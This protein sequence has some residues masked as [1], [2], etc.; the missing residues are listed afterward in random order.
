MPP[1]WSVNPRPEIVLPPGFAL[2]IDYDPESSPASLLITAYR[3]D[4]P[5]GQAHVDPREVGQRLRLDVADETT[6]ASTARELRLRLTPQR[7]QRAIV[8][9]AVR[10]PAQAREGVE[11]VEKASPLPAQAATSELPVVQAQPAMSQ[12]LAIPTQSS[13]PALEALHQLARDGVPEDLRGYDGDGP[14]AHNALVWLNNGTAV[15]LPS[16]SRPRPLHA[17]ATRVGRQLREEVAGEERSWWRVQRALRALS[18]LAA[19]LLGNPL[20]LR[21]AETEG[22]PSWR[23]SWRGAHPASGA[24]EG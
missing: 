9:E 5:V 3:D 12:P 8:M 14:R 4:A 2:R 11:A 10:E 20:Q 19:D 16:G 24:G 22:W 15:V 21:D 18:G 1:P 6:S 7:A 13:H 23:V 17:F